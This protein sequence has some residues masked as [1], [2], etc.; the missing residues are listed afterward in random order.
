VYNRQQVKT[1][2]IAIPSLHRPDLTARCIEFVQ[3]QTLP[4]GEWEIVVIENEAQADKILPDP[5][6]P[7]T[8]RIELTTNEGT[9]GSINR[10]VA[11]TDSRYILLLNNDIE[12]ESDYIARLLAAFDTDLK[13]G[14]AVGKLLR[15]TERD[16]LDGAGDAMLMAGAAYRLGHLNFDHGQFDQPMPALAG[17]GAAV[18]YRREAFVASGGLD[19]EFLAYLDDLDL[20][21]RAQLMGYTGAYVPGAVAYHIGS[22]TLGQ[23]LHPRVVEYVTRNQ[24][25]LL[26]K[27]YPRAVFLRLLPRIIVYQVLWM[28]SSNRRSGRGSSSEQHGSMRAQIRG[29]S[30]AIHNRHIMRQKGRELMTKRRIC[31]AEFLRRLRDSERQ[32]YDWQQSLPVQD[33]SS[34]LKFYFR[35]FG[36]P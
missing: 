35:L 34:L 15:A 8:R 27:D 26:I 9:T 18:L 25:Y 19:P 4:Y 22:A 7:N 32:I 1:V 10:A 12:L 6:P 11:A 33:R 29:W 2:A 20:A 14:F 30:A 13:L 5:L 36:R 16:H 31:D 21:L 17:C 24:I 23:P 3:K 28:V